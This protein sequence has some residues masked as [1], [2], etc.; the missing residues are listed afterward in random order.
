MS[1]VRDA[2]FM[3]LREAAIR[4]GGAAPVVERNELVSALAMKC[5][6]E[7]VLQRKPCSRPVDSTV[8]TMARLCRAAQLNCARSR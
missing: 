3:K 6:E 7:L 8:K 5:R 4:L 2:Q 1:D